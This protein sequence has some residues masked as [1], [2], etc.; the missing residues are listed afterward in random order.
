VKTLC[1]LKDE[2]EAALKSDPELEDVDMDEL[3][4]LTDAAN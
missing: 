1:A 4:Y 3:L 2:Y